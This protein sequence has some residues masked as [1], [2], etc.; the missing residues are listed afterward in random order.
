[1][2]VYI[3]NIYVCVCLYLYLYISISI[4]MCVCVY[5]VGILQRKPTGDL[6]ID[7]QKPTKLDV[8]HHWVYLT[9]L[10]NKPVNF[11]EFRRFLYVFILLYHQ[12]VGYLW[13]VLLPAAKIGKTWHEQTWTCFFRMCAGCCCFL[14]CLYIMLFAPLS[15]SS[16]TGFSPSFSLSWSPLKHPSFF[17]PMDPNWLVVYLPLWKIWVR[18]WEGWHPIYEMENSKHVSNH[19]PVQTT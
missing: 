17:N 14:M 4:S 3:Y 12:L 11:D 16:Q 7:P 6:G 5:G 18:Q 13:L 1:M 2:Y 10:W 8:E 15:L 9:G 19:Q